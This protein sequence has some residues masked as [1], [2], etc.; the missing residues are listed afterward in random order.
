[1]AAGATTLALATPQSASAADS[2]ADRVEFHMYGRIGMSWNFNGVLVE[3]KRMNL[4]GRAFGGRFEEGDYL[5]PTITTHILKPD[6]KEKDTYID[7]VITPSMFVRNGSFIGS[8]S[9][10]NP[11]ATL[12]IELFQAYLEAGNVFIPGL[13]FWGGARFYRGVDVHIAD[14]FY[15]NNLSGQGGGIMYKNLELAALIQ[16]GAADLLYAFDTNKDKTPD[17]QRARTVFTAQYALP[18]PILHEGTKLQFLSEFHVNPQLQRVREEPVAPTDLGGV[19]G[20]KLTLDF[21]NGNFNQTSF[22]YGGGIANGTQSYNAQT[23]YTFGLPD[24]KSGRYTGAYGIELVEHFLVNFGKIA[25][26]NGY[27]MF[28]ASQ[29]GDDRVTPENRVYDFATGAR[30]ALYAHKQYHLISELQYQG[31]K[32]GEDPWGT[33]LKATVAPTIVPTGEKSYWARP[34]MRLIYTA[35]F[36]NDQAAN[37]LMSQ[38]LQTIGRTK[39]AHYIGA[40]SEWWF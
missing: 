5:E 31:R 1:M 13:K 24:P 14:N 4:N 8:F 26:L 40:R 29:G 7:F 23:W 33:L 37:K 19:V 6:N 30:V 39:F 15:Y 21:G 3:G 22:R 36:Y 25:T 18:L 11:G 12:G 10:N 16:T 38:H 27:G 2:I 32:D 9:N 28:H 20:A 17:L 35:G 34:H